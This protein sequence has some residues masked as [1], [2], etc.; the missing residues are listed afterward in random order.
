[1][2][3]TSSSW[4]VRC[5]PISPTLA[6]RWEEPV[7]LVARRTQM[8]C[9][10][11]RGKSRMWKWKITRVFWANKTLQLS[12]EKTLLTV[13]LAWFLISKKNKGAKKLSWDWKS[14]IRKEHKDY[15]F[16][17]LTEVVWPL[18]L[19]WTLL[20]WQNV[21]SAEYRQL[22]TQVF[23]YRSFPKPW[24]SGWWLQRQ[25]CRAAGCPSKRA[26]ISSTGGALSSKVTL[27]KFKR[28]MPQRFNTCSP[29][30]RDIPDIGQSGNDSLYAASA[31]NKAWMLELKSAVSKLKPSFK[32][33]YLKEKDARSPQ[34]PQPQLAVAC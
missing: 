22:S 34:P 17:P 14:S 2:I 6:S 3:S 16:C 13:H 23:L 11:W 30:Y 24:H 5:P 21:S 12:K 18:H 9:W 7:P 33:T 32:Q 29:A 8:V 31:E 26:A 25:P 27:W 1:M 15:Q 10:F 19:H 4:C 28:Q 20:K